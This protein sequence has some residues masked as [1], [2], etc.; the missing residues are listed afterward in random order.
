MCVY[1]QRFTDMVSRK[2]E[3]HHIGRILVDI[4]AG[5]AG[6]GELGV[7]AVAD[8]V[9]GVRHAVVDAG[10]AGLGAAVARA[11]QPD[12]RPAALVLHHQRPAAVALAAVLAAAVVAGADHLVVDDDVDALVS[13]PLLAL[14]VVDHGHVHH[15]Q[16]LGPE[17]GA[18]LEGAPARGPAVV[19][20]QVH[21]LG[22]QTDG[23]DVGR[24]VHPSVQSETGET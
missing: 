1:V 22:R 16:R 12:Q 6:G 15:L 3:C 17:P 11:H 9:A 10:L 24:V 14:P 19:P 2:N 23:G 5:V 20:H 13:V 7:D 18:G 8:P 21:V 4:A